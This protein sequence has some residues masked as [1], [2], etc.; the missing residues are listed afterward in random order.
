MM[1]IHRD[2]RGKYLKIGLIEDEALEL[3][4]VLMPFVNEDKF[5]CFWQNFP[6]SFSFKEMQMD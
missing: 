3:S 5:M 1:V 4:C 2:P 6:N